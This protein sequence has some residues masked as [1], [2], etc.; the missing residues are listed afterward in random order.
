MSNVA[1]G[2]D[3]FLVPL[4]YTVGSGFRTMIR[5]QFVAY[6]EVWFGGGRLL[7]ADETKIQD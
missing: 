5:D 4:L 1:H 6:W 7:S 2:D 3:P